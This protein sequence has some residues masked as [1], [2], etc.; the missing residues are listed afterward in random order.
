[1]VKNPAEAG[2]G[3]TLVL[4]KSEGALLLVALGSGRLLFIFQKGPAH[5]LQEED[6]S[7]I[8]LAWKLTSAK[9][10]IKPML[11]ATKS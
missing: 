10:I 11:L 7:A 6:R 3:K 4:S 5:G 8:K 9:M 2:L 1:M